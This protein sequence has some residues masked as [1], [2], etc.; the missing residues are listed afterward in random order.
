MSHSLDHFGHHALSCKNGSNVVSCHNRIRDTLF[1]FCQHACLGAQLEAGSS[2]GHEVRQTC[3]A[4]VLIP[5][6]DLGKPV[7]FDLCVTSRKPSK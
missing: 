3:P 6:W 1:E 7:A 4:D 5:N 2:L